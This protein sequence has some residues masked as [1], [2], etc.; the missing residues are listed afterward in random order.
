[1][2]QTQIH[3]ARHLRNGKYDPATDLDEQLTTADEDCLVGM[4]EGGEATLA[5]MQ[6]VGGVVLAARI[7]KAV[8]NYAQE[9][10]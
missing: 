6:V 2:T 9:E 3:I 7:A 5:D 4:V 10:S 8:A 1:M